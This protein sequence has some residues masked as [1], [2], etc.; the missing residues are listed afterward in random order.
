MVKALALLAGGLVA[1]V[2]GVV[3]G[4]VRMRTESVVGAV[5]MHATMNIVAVV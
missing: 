3:A 4:H 5:L 1:F 2:F